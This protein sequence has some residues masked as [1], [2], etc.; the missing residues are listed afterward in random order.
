MAL[1]IFHTFYLDLNEGPFMCKLVRTDLV[2]KCWAAAEQLRQLVLGAITSF[3]AWE[4]KQNTMMITM[5]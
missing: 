3:L 4:I 2:S 1:K 5:H